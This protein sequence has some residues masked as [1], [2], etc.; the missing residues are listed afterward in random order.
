MIG[1]AY[2]PQF[3]AEELAWR[4]KLKKDSAVLVLGS[5][6]DRYMASFT[7]HGLA[8]LA[9]GAFEAFTRGNQQLPHADGVFKF[10]FIPYA[11]PEFQD[12]S[13]VAAECYR[14]LKHSGKIFIL[15]QSHEQLRRKPLFKF[16]PEAFDRQISRYISI[17]DLTIVLG[18]VGFKS[19]E[20]SSYYW[21]GSVKPSDYVEAAERNLCPEL[22]VLPDE[23]RHQG[24]ERLRGYITRRGDEP[25]RDDDSSTLITGRKEYLTNRQKTFSS[26]PMMAT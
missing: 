3:W 2:R 10:V 7:K 5:E 15:T 8:A 12:G 9:S 23:A 18:K 24:I 17:P 19:I 11:W 22:A 20:T 26:S 21:A 16:F 13:R 6:E 4:A 1:N 14:V 25:F